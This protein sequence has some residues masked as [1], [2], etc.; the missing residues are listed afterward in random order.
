MRYSQRSTE[1]K[2]IVNFF[3]ELG[4]LKKTPRS[5]FQFLGSGRESVADHVFRVTTIGFTLARLDKEAD[6]FTVVLMCLF[7]DLPESRTGDLNYVNKRY[8]DVKED[9]AIKDLAQTLPFGDEIEELLE[10]FTRGESREAKLARDADQLDLI[11]GLKEHQD[12]GNRYAEDW[13]NFARK[14]LKTDLGRQLAASIVETD[15]TAWWFEGKDHWWT[16]E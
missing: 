2:S 12:L 8:V 10:D 14:R 9:Q 16:E 11:L 15:S 13:I 5:G 3:F 7:H 6:A 1:L 4:M